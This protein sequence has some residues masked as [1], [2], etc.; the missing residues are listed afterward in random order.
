MALSSITRYKLRKVLKYTLVTVAVA[1]VLTLFSGDAVRGWLGAWALLGLWTGVLEE[2]LFGRRYRSLAVP[3]QFLGKALAVNAL[4]IA[5]VALAF[6]F[7][8]EQNLPLRSEGAFT[9]SEMLAMAQFYRLILRVAV[10]TSV[11]ILIV[12]VEE[13][14]GRRLFLG[15]VLGRYERPLAEQRIVLSMDLVGSTALAERMGDLRYFRFLNTTYSLMTDALLRNEAEIHKY[16]GDEVIFTWPMEVGL[17]QGNCLDLYFDITERIAAHAEELQQEFGAV[18]QFRGALH[19]GRVIVAQIGHIKRAVDFNG[20]VM[21]SVSRML[22]VCKDL[23]EDLV[24]S[25]EMYARFTASRERFRFGAE[26]TMPV[27][28]RKREV[29]VHSV[30][31]VAKA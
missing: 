4:T 2:F 30:E 25:A 12:Q 20:D 1:W 3:L 24:V 22:G 19:G 18:P 23:K 29:R 27:K 5:L 9:P 14:I 15:I 11:A 28:G 13:L 6:A 7:D 17:S 16:V 26:R 10:V 31:R 21:N 8:R